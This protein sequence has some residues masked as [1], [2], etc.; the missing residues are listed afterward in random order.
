VLFVSIFAGY[1]ADGFGQEYIREFY[2]YQRD[3]EAYAPMLQT[4]TALFYRAVQT[5]TD[6]YGANTDYNLPMVAVGRRGRTYADESTLLNG[7]PIENYR[8]CALLRI[9][10]ASEETYPG[11]TAPEGHS[12]AGE[13]IRILRF[14]EAI[15]LRPYY[16]ALSLTDRNY[17]LG[18]RTRQ[19]LARHGGARS[20]H[21]PRP[22]HRRSIHRCVDG[23]S[24]IRQTILGKSQ[25]GNRFHRA[26][27]D[28]RRTLG[29]DHRS[30][31]ADG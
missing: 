14:D 5:A 26:A 6:L 28:T 12:G 8:T 3:A 4:D 22:A 17:R 16:A 30:F 7:M 2:P 25:A 20:P 29:I 1:A 19:R 15:Q 27:F 24:T 11:A 9:L 18:R 31:P 10:G 21:G 23:R 13:G